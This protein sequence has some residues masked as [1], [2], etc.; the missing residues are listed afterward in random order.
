MNYTLRDLVNS[1]KLIAKSVFGK[2]DEYELK[3]NH[4]S[5]GC[6]YIDFP[7][8]PFDHHNLMMVAGADDLCAFLSEDD[9][10]VTVK[11]IPSKKDEEHPGY[12]KLT[13]TEHGLT[14]GSTYTV[15]GLDGFNKNVW[16]CPV[17]LFVLGEYPKYIYLK[18]A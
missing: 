4:E 9:K 12:C 2:K 1:S 14:S 13:Q 5:D 18:R 10:D 15:D 7:N 11:V 3:F 6:W 17:T 16:I 8:W